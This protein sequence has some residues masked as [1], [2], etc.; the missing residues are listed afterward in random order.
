MSKFSLK[1]KTQEIVFETE[2]GDVAYTLKEMSAA[3][4]DAYLQKLSS[5]VSLGP[6]GTPQGVSNFDGLQAEL[7]S[8]CLF[9][10]DKAVGIEAIQEWP[11]GVVAEIYNQCQE[12]NGLNQK[13]ASK[14]E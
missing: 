7:I 3:A 9:K 14:N 10:G 8:V 1:R 4:R 2:G 11:A 5:R 12:M 13:V 6:D